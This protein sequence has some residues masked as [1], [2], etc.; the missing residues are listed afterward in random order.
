MAEPSGPLAGYTVALAETRQ[1]D[2]LANLLER[3]GASTWRCPL[4]SILDAPD[5]A[6]VLAWID[7][8]IAEP[9]PWTI[10]LTGEGLRRLL[11]AAERHERKA[12]LLA[13]MAQTQ[14]VT[15]G[16]KPVRELKQ[17]GLKSA[18]PATTPTT[19]GVCEALAEVPLAGQRV[20]V[21][22]YGTDPNL[23]LIRFLE[24]KGAHVEPVAPYIYASEADEARVLA[25]LDALAA[26]D[27][28]C[29]AFTSQP[30][31]RRLAQVAAKHQRE[32][33]LAA[34]LARIKVAAVGPVV[35]EDLRRRGVA[36]DLMPTDA[37]FM[38]PLVAE[39]TRSL[40]GRD[41]AGL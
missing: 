39:I 12:S 15:R 22:L 18:L 23:P 26:G 35:A 2:V 1:L 9:P 24:D 32:A 40:T 6:P 33:E 36:P 11:T 29:I 27:I 17:H 13:A 19:A 14:F 4:V 16:P 10:L 41:D 3:R 30:Q 5:P 20:A 25:L 7:R 21:Q 37:F 8:Y 28:H 38:K 34:S 31:Y